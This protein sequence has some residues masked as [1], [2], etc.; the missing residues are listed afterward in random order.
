M[1]VFSRETLEE[2]MAQAVSRS[3]T[4][5]LWP[6]G[7]AP[8]RK[9]A[10]LFLRQNRGIPVH[11]SSIAPSRASDLLKSPFTRQINPTAWGFS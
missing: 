6:D 7:E 8:E 10:M 5:T 11:P 3:A 9:T 1:D 2:M 4:F